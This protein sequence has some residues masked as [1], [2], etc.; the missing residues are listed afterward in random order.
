MTRTMSSSIRVGKTSNRRRPAPNMALEQVVPD[1]DRP[2]DGRADLYAFGVV[3]YELLTGRVPFKGE[4][5]WETCYQVMQA[6]LPRPR[7]LNPT[8]PPTVEAILLQALAR[9]RDVRFATGAEFEAALRD[10]VRRSAD[11]VPESGAHDAPTLHAAA[12]S[13]TPHPTGGSDL[14]A[15]DGERLVSCCVRPASPRCLASSPW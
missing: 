15:A 3:L 2:L 5:T 14:R 11:G 12:T 4:T 9:N 7:E 6:P 13:S 10:G 8:L 1:P